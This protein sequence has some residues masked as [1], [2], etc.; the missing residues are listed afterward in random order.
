MSGHSIITFK[1]KEI[2]YHDY[3]GKTVDQMLQTLNLALE[4]A[5]KDNKK[6]PRLANFT[7]AYAV[8][9]FMKAVKEAGLQTRHLTPKA[10]IVGVTRAKTIILNAYNLFTKTNMKAFED[11]ESAKEWL[12]KS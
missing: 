3:R 6:R 5:L 7:D 11:E 9:E 4:R 10:A 1:G 2:S 12:V 8:P